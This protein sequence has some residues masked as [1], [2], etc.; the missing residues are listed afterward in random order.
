MNSHQLREFIK[1]QEGFK[2]SLYKDTE[3]ILTGGY[4]HAFHED[5]VLPDYVWEEIF[6]H[7]LMVAA[8]GFLMLGLIGLNHCRRVVVVSMIFQLGLTGVKRFKRFLAALRRHDYETAVVE[9]YDSKW[10]RQT[11][12]RVE[13]LAEMVY[14]GECTL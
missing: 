4:G 11:P 6:T 10:Y 8:N 7:D 1:Q 2:R 5:S 12:N 13:E 3:G 9:M 14:Y